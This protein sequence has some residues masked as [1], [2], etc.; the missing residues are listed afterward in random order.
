MQEIARSLGADIGRFYHTLIPES[1]VVQKAN[2]RREARDTLL[3]WY[4]IESLMK[5][6]QGIA[7]QYVKSILAEGPSSPLAREFMNQISVMARNPERKHPSFENAVDWIPVVARAIKNDKKNL[8]NLSYDSI[9]YFFAQFAYPSAIRNLSDALY[10]HVR[11]QGDRF[12]TINPIFTD[13]EKRVVWKENNMVTI[14]EY[15]RHWYLAKY[16]SEPVAHGAILALLDIAMKN[17]GSA[18]TVDSILKQKL[19]DGEH[20]MKRIEK[21]TNSMDKVTYSVAERPRQYKSSGYVGEF[22]FKGRL[23][24][25]KLVT[26]LENNGPLD[27]TWVA[28]FVVEESGEVIAMSKEKEPTVQTVQTE[29]NA[30]QLAFQK[31]FRQIIE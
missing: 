17:Q 15:V 16:K 10:I 19:L 31:G 27:D 12:P 6:E 7:T 11:R 30:L 23:L 28:H 21:R 13:A 4:G 26:S 3:R 24:K 5:V 9:A 2:T 1:L 20:L 22:P 29:E 14:K 25:G 18:D 8:F